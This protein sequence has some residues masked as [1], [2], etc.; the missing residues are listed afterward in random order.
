MCRSPTSLRA[1]A[2]S[3]GR[4]VGSDDT[5]DIQRVKTVVTRQFLDNTYWVNNPMMIAG[6]RGHRRQSRRRCAALGSAPLSTYKKGDSAGTAACAYIGDK[7][8]LALQHF[9]QV[10]EMRTGVSRSTMALDPEALQNQT[11]T[12]ANNQK[13]SAYSQIELIA[14]NQAEL[15]WR[16]CSARS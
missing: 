15:G 9:D 7:A 11:A 5:S 6:R 4:A 1:C 16:E 10:R 8:L 13:D 12:A 14:R 2:P 3:L